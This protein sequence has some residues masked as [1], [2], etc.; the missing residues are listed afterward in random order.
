MFKILKLCTAKENILAEVYFLLLW[1]K[2]FTRTAHKISSPW[3]KTLGPCVWQL[4]KA[5]LFTGFSFDPR[6]IREKR[7]NT[8]VTFVFARIF[9]TM[10]MMTPK[11][12][13][14]KLMLTINSKLEDIPLIKLSFICSS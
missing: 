10:D 12:E 13:H 7:E 14:F 6:K 2:L 1:V 11:K 8:L 5:A 4:I 9:Q 3:K